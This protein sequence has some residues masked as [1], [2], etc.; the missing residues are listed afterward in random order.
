MQERLP[1][2][3]GCTMLEKMVGRR[4]AGKT[5]GEKN[6]ITAYFWAGEAQ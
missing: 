3:P 6:T 5:G 4:R 2:R 1:T